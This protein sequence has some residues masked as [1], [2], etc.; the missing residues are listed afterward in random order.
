MKLGTAGSRASQKRKKAGGRLVVSDDDED[1]NSS[2]SSD[3]SS[4]DDD[5]QILS[6]GVSFA[7]ILP[8]SLSIAPRGVQYLPFYLNA[9]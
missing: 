2:E 8:P 1:S 9:Q 7:N 6:E 5:V 3:D 4:K